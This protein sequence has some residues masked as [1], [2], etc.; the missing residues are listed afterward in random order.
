M[1]PRGSLVSAVIGR[2]IRRQLI[3]NPA[4]RRGTYR[5]RNPIDV[6]A[7]L[8]YVTGQVAATPCTPCKK[9]HG[10]WAECV[11]PLPGANLEGRDAEHCANCIYQSQAHKCQFENGQ[12]QLSRETGSEQIAN[13]PGTPSSLSLSNAV[14]ELFYHRFKRYV[15]A[16]PAQRE[17]IKT[18]AQMDLLAAQVLATRNVGANL[19]G[20]A[21]EEGRTQNPCLYTGE[22]GHPLSAEDNDNELDDYD[23]ALHRADPRGVA[24]SQRDAGSGGKDLE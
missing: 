2:P 18:N 11:V 10:P 17:Q 19:F 16:T 7:A 9:K 12:P 23:R 1:P 14:G 4:R 20:W 15:R 13:I 3:A 8:I 5:P 6:I 22:P 21:Q 24:G